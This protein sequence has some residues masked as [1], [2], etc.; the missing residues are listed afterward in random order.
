MP[1]VASVVTGFMQITLMM[2]SVRVS[3]EVST[4]APDSQSGVERQRSV[5]SLIERAIVW[6]SLTMTNGLNGQNGHK[7]KLE[8][9]LWNTADSLRGKMCADEFRDCCLGFIFYKYLS[10][11][12]ASMPM[13]C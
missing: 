2:F 7:K 12:N 1:N 8:T 13:K 4:V 10:N 11:S 3:D 6:L 5:V 9:Q